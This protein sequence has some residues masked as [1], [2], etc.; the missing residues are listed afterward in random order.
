[1]FILS[2]ACYSTKIGSKLTRKSY[3][4]LRGVYGQVNSL[5]KSFY[6]S[7]SS[8]QGWLIISKEPP[9]VPSLFSGFFYKSFKIKS[10]D[11]LEVIIF[12]LNLTC[13]INVFL[14]IF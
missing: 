4:G 2:V 10:F 6:Q 12:D 3:P 1:M 14:Y 5:D 13:F 8:N 7:K 11:S 9:K